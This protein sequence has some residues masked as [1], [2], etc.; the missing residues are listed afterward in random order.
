MAEAYL[1][2]IDAGTTVAKSVVFDLNGNEIAKAGKPVDTI[3]P[4]PGWMEH[5][6]DQVWD[7]VA[8]SISQAIKE[9]KVNPRDIK[10]VS[11]S[12][13]GA[14]SWFVAKD[15]RPTRNAVGWA[16]G[17]AASIID[18]WRESGNLE[19]IFEA[20]GFMYY[21]ASGPGI[22]MPWFK[23]N[24]PEVLE[25]SKAV[26]WCNDWVRYCLTG[27]IYTDESNGSI[28]MFDQKK[29]AYYDKVFELAG[30]SEYRHLFPDIRQSHELGGKV[31]SQASA[32]TGLAEGTPVAMGA[33]DCSS[34]ALGAGCVQQGDATSIMGTAGIHLCV[35][36]EPVVNRAYSLAC[37]AVPGRWL[38]NSMA[39]TAANNLDWFERE[40]CLAERQQAE[41]QGVSKYEVIN[42]EV[43]GVPVGSNGIMYLPFLQ[44]ERAPFVEPRARAEFFGIGNWT[45][46][47]DLMRAVYEGVALATR[48]NYTE[49]EK[50][51]PFDEVRLGGG[52]AQ[53]EVWTQIIADCTGKTMKVTSGTEFGARGAA[54]NAAVALGIYKDH[55]EA[56]SNMVRV[57]RVQEPDLSKT[58]IYGKMFDL[59]VKLVE[60]DRQV[61]VEMCELVDSTLSGQKGCV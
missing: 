54:I 20:S 59:Y 8:S 56:V 16:D 32:K 55:K 60:R 48:H 35:S 58:E 41:K 50:G 19:A 5:D 31:T 25:K 53:S 37:H 57:S 21:S 18:R 36:S 9:A 29:R 51:V 52:G 30:I 26:M 2:G 34:T 12:A 40:F 1:V 28:A 7:A 4:R 11:F 49:M 17:R 46:R 39:M 3:H 42:R 24:E 15:G 33:W 45:K 43:A 44:G 23:E 38:V 27:E 14:G 61:W 22:I 13:Q 6:M 10:G 47:A